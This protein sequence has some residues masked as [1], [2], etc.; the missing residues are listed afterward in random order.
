M[1]AVVDRNMPGGNVGY[2]LRDEERIKLRTVLH[3]LPI[4]GYL[5][6]ERTDTTNAYAIDDSNAVLI[7]FLQINTTILYTLN[8]AYHSQ[9][10]VTI[11]LASLFAIKP[12]SY[13]KVLN[14]TSKLSLELGSIEL[15]NG[16]SAALTGQHGLPCL[17]R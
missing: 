6:L 12:I 14:L 7:L 10:S 16:S 3:M 17:L 15:C 1:E 5:I 4:I 11:Q 2:H 13:I 9:L 8:G